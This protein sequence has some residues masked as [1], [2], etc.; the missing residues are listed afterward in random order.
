MNSCCFICVFAVLIN[1]VCLQVTVEAV[2]GGSV[3]LP[4]SSDEHDHTLQDIDLHL[5]FPQLQKYNPTQTWSDNFRSGMDVTAGICSGS[6]VGISS[7]SESAVG[8]GSGSVVGMGS[9]QINE[10]MKN[11]EGCVPSS[12]IKHSSSSKVRMRMLWPIAFSSSLRATLFSSHD[13]TVRMRTA[14]TYKI[15]K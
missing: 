14:G 6:M 3:V 4:C 15:M 10:G 12:P 1:K 9:A 8:S 7:G 5:R 13:Q 11:Q 2:I